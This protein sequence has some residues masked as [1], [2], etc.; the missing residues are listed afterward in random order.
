MNKGL[1]SQQFLDRSGFLFVAAVE[2][3][4]ELPVVAVTPQLIEWVKEV[5]LV[6][7]LAVVTDAAVSSELAI[8]VIASV[9]AVGYDL[10]EE[11]FVVVLVAVVD[12]DNSG[13]TDETVAADTAGALGSVEFA[14]VLHCSVTVLG[15][16]VGFVVATVH[17]AFV[18]V[19]LLAQH[20]MI[21]VAV[22]S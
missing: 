8:V 11:I 10:D 3:F 5:V 16:D 21:A 2:K 20:K 15:S 12:L 7:E 13:S 4:Q 1:E 22:A 14:V 6:N 19:A 9:V 18:A 17:V